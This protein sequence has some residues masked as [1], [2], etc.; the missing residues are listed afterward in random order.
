MDGQEESVAKSRSAPLLSGPDAK[1]MDEYEQSQQREDWDT[2]HR[3]IAETWR[4]LFVKHSRRPTYGE[5][6]VETKLHINTVTK[7]FKTLTLDR[8]MESWRGQSDVVMAGLMKAIAKGNPIAVKVYYEITQGLGKD[9]NVNLGVQ[10]GQVLT[11]GGKEIS[12]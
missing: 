7:H 11:I 2:N 10:P 6:A 9:H 3:I 5:I 4:R 12:F 8:L 1:T